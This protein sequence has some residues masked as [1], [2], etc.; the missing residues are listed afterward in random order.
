MAINVL[1]GAKMV[2]CRQAIFTLKDSAFAIVAKWPSAC[3]LLLLTP[4]ALF[5]IIG[6]FMI[7]FN[8]NGEKRY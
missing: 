6:N 5:C 8:E 1:P 7:I 4:F 3:F 2:L